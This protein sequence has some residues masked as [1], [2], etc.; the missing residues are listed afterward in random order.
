MSRKSLRSTVAGYDDV[1]PKKLQHK[2]I[3]K[4]YCLVGLSDVLALVLHEQIGGCGT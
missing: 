1:L 4:V 3:G 2:V